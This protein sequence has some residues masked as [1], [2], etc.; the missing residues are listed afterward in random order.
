M[1]CET[2]KEILDKWMHQVW[3]TDYIALAVDAVNDTHFPR[4]MYTRQQAKQAPGTTCGASIYNICARS[5]TPSLFRGKIEKR[6]CYVGKFFRGLSDA[7]CNLNAHKYLIP[8]LAHTEPISR[9]IPF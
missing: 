8:C 9:E 3:N 7:L 6:V 1:E 5:K 2:S 4:E